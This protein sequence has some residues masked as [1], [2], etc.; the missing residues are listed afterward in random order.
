MD[1]FTQGFIDA[2]DE[3]MAKDA[4]K[5]AALYHQL[6]TR[7]ALRNATNK[8]YVFPPKNMGKSGESYRYHRGMAKAHMKKK[9]WRSGLLFGMIRPRTA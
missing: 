3:G 5:A 9:D 1:T 4:G 6:R 8:T 2:L 7:I